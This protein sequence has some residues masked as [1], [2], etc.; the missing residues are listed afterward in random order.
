M[1]QL[2]NVNVGMKHLFEGRVQEAARISSQLLTEAPDEALV[3]FLACEVAIAQNLAG[4]ALDHINRA[5]DLDPQEPELRLKQADVELIHRQGLRA[6]AIASEVAAR[7][8]DNVQVQLAAARIFTRCGNHAGAEAYLLNAGAKDR[9]NPRFLFDYSTNQFFLGKTAEAEKAIADFLDLGLPSSGRKLLLRSQL[10]KQTPTDNHVAGLKNYL[11]QPLPKREA[12]NC[13]YA[14]AKELEDLGEFSQSFEALRSGASTQRQLVNFNLAGELK[15]IEDI[16]ETFQS[17]N[18]ASI[19]DSNVQDAPVFIVGMPRTG[20]TLVARIVSR[21]GGVKSAE[22]SND[23]TFAFSSVINNYI[24]ANPGKNLTPLS[25]ALE[26]DY[27]EIAAG[28]LGHMRGML[29]EAK[30]YMDKTPFNFL[31]CGLIRKAFPKARILHLVRNPMDTCYAVFKTL[32]NQAYYYSYNLEELAGYYIGYRKLMDHWHNLMPG[33]ILDV[34]YEELVSNPEDVSKQI[35][36]YIGFDWSEDLH[37]I[38][39]SAEP[40][41]TASAAQVRAPIHTSSVGLWRRFEAELAP[42]SQKLSAANLL[43]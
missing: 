4:Q 40:C 38:E 28:Y 19:P 17:A 2:E 16:I 26:V 43:G 34:S 33:A 21:H 23:F 36:A 10:K 14:L 41:S 8:P 32:F 22:E 9:K 18:F 5:V 31:Y 39:D 15:N 27:G 25:A 20:T 24:S 37:E 1:N 30:C 29:G 6:Q 13:Y 42:V 7:L 11:A 3:H 35:A 12:V